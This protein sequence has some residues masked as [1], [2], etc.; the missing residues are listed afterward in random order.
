MKNGSVLKI[1]TT[2][3]DDTPRVGPFINKL[4]KTH[5]IHLRTPEKAKGKLKHKTEFNIFKFYILKL[6]EWECKQLIRTN[7]IIKTIVW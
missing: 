3:Q 6:V 4:R 1:N 5:Y 7:A 2:N